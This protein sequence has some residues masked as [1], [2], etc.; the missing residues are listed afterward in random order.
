M[1]TAKF[2]TIEKD[3]IVIF[4]GSDDFVPGEAQILN[5][6]DELD[7]DYLLRETARQEEQE[8]EEKG[9]QRWISV[10]VITVVVSFI[11]AVSYINF[12]GIL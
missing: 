2:K 11:V 4:D 6:D 1:N 9:K 5:E 7:V 12:R 3:G 10:A 8:A